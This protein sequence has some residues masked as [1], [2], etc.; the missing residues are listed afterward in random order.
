M[1]NLAEGAKMLLKLFLMGIITALPYVFRKLYILSYVSLAVVIILLI[2]AD[3]RIKKKRV[4][5]LQG[6][7]FGL[8]YFGTVFMW[9]MAVYP[10][11]FAG[12]G[13][14]QAA[15]LLLFCW[16]GLSAL[17]AFEFGFV[18]LFFYLARPSV[19]KPLKSGLVFMLL[20]VVF[21]WQQTLF[22]RGVPWARLAL[23]QAESPALL[24]NASLFGS[25]FTSGLIVFINVLIACAAIYAMNKI[26]LTR[27]FNENPATDSTGQTIGTNSDTSADSEKN[28]EIRAHT[29]SVSGNGID[30]EI[31][32]EI[33][34]HSESS[35]GGRN[36]N[37]LNSENRT[38]TELN[39]GVGADDKAGLKLKSAFKNESLKI[40]EALKNKKTAL[41]AVA[42]L[43]VFSLNLIYGTVR[44]AVIENETEDTQLKAAVI[45]GNISSNEKWGSGSVEL[46]LQRYEELTLKCVEETGAEIVVWPETAI[47][48]KIRYYP[49]AVD[50]LSSL[51]EELGIYM[52]VGAFDLQRDSEGISR[53][54]NAM[55]MFSPDG[56]ISDNIYCKRHL[57]PFGEYVP[58]REIVFTLLPMLDS[59]SML[60]DDLTPG[61]D[62][63]VF[64]FDGIKS[65]SLIC[66]DSIYE[67][68]ALDAVRDGAE[69][70]M[71]STNDSWFSDSAALTQHCN[72]ARL[73]AI[74]TGRYVLRAANTGISSIIDPCG[75]KITTIPAL[76]TGYA[77]ADI[78]ARG[79]RTLYSYVGNIF[80]YLCITFLTAVF[81]YKAVMK[82]KSEKRREDKNT[83][84]AGTE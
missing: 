47:P 22:W 72:H 6:F 69:I 59:L 61:T 58:M 65:A 12:I 52:F 57:V 56:S 13:K 15:A 37:E 3:M 81:V 41:F 73:R 39:N 5:Y 43:C 74:E 21:E 64:E 48:I 75:N 31:D 67:T 14:A 40:F 70:L 36:D 66:F 78:T 55:F 54:Y 24:Q 8:G 33:G 23:T 49:Q 76:E 10:M 19:T 4:A 60:S 20:W 29:S 30:N 83:T 77:A 27:N 34:F 9:F 26:N 71:I 16:F 25:L 44:M 35:P 28:S 42:A 82:L 46:C 62:S 84:S 11:E 17:Q 50:R 1:Y 51:A 80:P 63:N 38:N 7:V 32:F 2:L 53:E 45:Q 68:L 18:T 79:D